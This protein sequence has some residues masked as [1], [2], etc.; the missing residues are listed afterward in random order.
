MRRVLCALLAVCMSL[1]ALL[2]APMTAAATEGTVIVLEGVKQEA[3]RIRVDVN[4]RENTGV[5]A[6]VLTL[7]YDREALELIEV[8]H[9]EALE[10]LSPLASA[11]YTVDPYRISYLGTDQQNDTSTGR[12]MTLTFAVR[13]GAPDGDYTITL[14]YEKNRDVTW[15]S[16]QQIVTKNL[17]IG[18]VTVTLS[19]ET[20]DA[21]Q[22]LP[23]DTDGKNDFPIAPVAA[24]IALAGLSLCIV[25]MLVTHK[26]RGRGKT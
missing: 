11:D 9:G 19:S 22:S 3:E 15:L 16:E 17:V 20:V 2:A 23:T 25:W 7:R 5:Y 6:M 13:K 10:S 14:D 12:L 18:G 21:I 24:G 8:E 26:R 1:S 4:L